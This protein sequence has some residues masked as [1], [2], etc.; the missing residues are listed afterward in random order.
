MLPQTWDP[1]R[2]K[3]LPAVAWAVGS[4]AGNRCWPLANVLSN[5]GLPKH[6]TGAGNGENRL[7]FIHQ[8]L[9]D[10]ARADG[11]ETISCTVKTRHR[12][13]ILVYKKIYFF[14]IL[15][16]PLWPLFDAW[17]LGV[18]EEAWND[19]NLSFTLWLRFVSSIPFGVAKVI[20][21]QNYSTNL[22]SFL[23]TT[24]DLSREISGSS[25]KLRHRFFPIQK[26]LSHWTCQ[27]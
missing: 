6:R 20:V 17:V 3:N 16:V 15:A 11:R 7:A 4:I 21:L 19:H 27:Y 2:Q 18:R 8:I 14:L 25:L 1:E 24:H 12:S 5:S 26:I 22:R 23:C 10:E 9:S 13:W